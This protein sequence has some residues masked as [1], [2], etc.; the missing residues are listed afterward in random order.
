MLAAKLLV[1]PAAQP[2]VLA[3][4][5]DVWEARQESD[6]IRDDPA[7][8]FASQPNDIEAAATPAPEEAADVPAAFDVA[9]H[10][11]A[12]EEAPAAAPHAVLV[13]RHNPYSL[14]QPLAKIFACECQACAVC[15]E[16]LA[17]AV[18]TA[19]APL[20][21][22]L[23]APGVDDAFYDDSAE[24]EDAAAVAADNQDDDEAA[25]YDVAAAAAAVAVE[26]VSRFMPPP[27]PRRDTYDVIAACGA[28]DP[29]AAIYAM[30][31]RWF[32]KAVA[33]EPFFVDEQCPRPDPS[34]YDFV[35]WCDQVNAWWF[36]HFEHRQK[37][38]H[39]HHH[40]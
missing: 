37:K 36:R 26:P 29:D 2:V 24:D 10:A 40:W 15:Q 25:A 35:T 11:A 3:T 23:A 30:M 8:K 17:P 39:R 14:Q 19:A 9:P 22:A 33:V 1:A 32:T 6:I 13:I 7:D 18:A 12:E 20:E 38:V 31:M 16:A 5:G 21:A 27:P 28:E 34:R 4:F